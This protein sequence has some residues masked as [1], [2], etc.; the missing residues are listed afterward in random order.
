MKDVCDKWS[1]EFNRT[2]EESKLEFELNLK[3]QQEEYMYLKS[4]YYEPN[5]KA[6]SAE[7]KEAL[8]CLPVG[9]LN[10][11]RELESA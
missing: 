9:G 5:K 1:E 10:G 2:T 3:Q 7:T 4:K 8:H 6:S 11:G